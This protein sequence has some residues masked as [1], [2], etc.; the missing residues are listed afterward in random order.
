MTILHRK[1]SGFS[2][3]GP[4]FGTR[5][6]DCPNLK[7]GQLKNTYALIISENQTLGEIADSLKKMGSIYEK[8]G[9]VNQCRIT[10]EDD[11]LWIFKDES[12]IPIYDD[13]GHTDEIQRKLGGLKIRTVLI[14]ESTSSAGGNRLVHDVICEISKKIPAVWE[15]EDSVFHS[16]E[17]LMKRCSQSSNE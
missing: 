5:P 16:H 10:K 7:Y 4:R 14:L 12:M 13:M 9:D 1:R 6:D 11:H 15:S 3:Y 2:G 17:D 8:S